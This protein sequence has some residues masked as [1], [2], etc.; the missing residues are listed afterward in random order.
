MGI[1]RARRARKLASSWG[2]GSLAGEGVEPACAHGLRT[3]PLPPALGPSALG[4]RTKGETVSWLREGGSCWGGRRARRVPPRVHPKAHPPKGLGLGEA[5]LCLLS[6]QLGPRSLDLVP[7]LKVLLILKGS[8]LNCGHLGGVSAIS[9][10]P[11]V[12][13]GAVLSVCGWESAYAEAG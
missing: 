13:G 7:T 11:R 4:L 5:S 9:S 10:N 2:N 1:W 12:R 8:G 6:G 3:F